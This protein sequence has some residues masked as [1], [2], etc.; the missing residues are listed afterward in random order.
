MDMEPTTLEK[1]VGA[2]APVAQE[3]LRQIAG[4][5]Q[6]TANV[7]TVF[8]APLELDGHTIIPVAA[9]F[10]SFGGGA[11][12]GGVLA[13][14]LEGAASLA[15]RVL[16]RVLAGGAGGGLNVSVRPVGFIHD[17]KGG[18]AFTPIVTHHPAQ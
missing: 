15:G 16:P 18:V 3:I 1:T 13:K 4:V 14:V 2:R 11:G 8:G 5:L 10:L 12:A 7:Q 17:D 9:L 6:N